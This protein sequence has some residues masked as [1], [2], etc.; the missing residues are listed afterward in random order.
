[1]A[2]K[3]SLGKKY[4]QLEKTVNDFLQSKGVWDIT[5]IVLVEELIFNKYLAD[6]SKDEI[7]E[8]GILVN[9]RQDPGKEPLWQTNQA[10]S[11]YN[12][13]VKNIHTLCTKLG[14]TVQE[15]TKLR[16]ADANL[17]EIDKLI[18]QQYK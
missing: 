11:T 10:V 17:D 13:A 9:V 8:F 5:D 12:N 3:P 16:L 6:Q 18:E 1:M 2:R 4:T 14:M 15:R 7:R